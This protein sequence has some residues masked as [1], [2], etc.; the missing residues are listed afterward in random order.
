MLSCRLLCPVVHA[1]LLYF[2]RNFS[3]RTPQSAE[4]S[5]YGREDEKKL[6]MQRPAGLLWK[7]YL[8]D[9]RR[10]VGADIVG[11]Q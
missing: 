9:R 1:V 5:N 4:A 2:L 6:S 10:T 8:M 3:D 7:P 11:L